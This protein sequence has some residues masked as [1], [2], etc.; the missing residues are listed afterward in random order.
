MPQLPVPRWPARRALALVLAVIGAI[1]CYLPSR[2][3]SRVNPAEVLR[4]Q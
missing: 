3:A 4:A 2:R 1:A